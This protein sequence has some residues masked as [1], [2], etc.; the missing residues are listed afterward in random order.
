MAKCDH[1][2]YEWSSESLLMF[3]SCPSCR[4]KTRR[5]PLKPGDKGVEKKRGRS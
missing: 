1:C 3:V 5:I 4:A 2:A